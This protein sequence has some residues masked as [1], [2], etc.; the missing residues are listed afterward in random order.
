MTALGKPMTIA[1]SL[2]VV[3]DFYVLVSKA[4]SGTITFPL[5]QQRYV[6]FRGWEGRD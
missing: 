5:I 3:G 4:Y 2:T 1:F 6:L